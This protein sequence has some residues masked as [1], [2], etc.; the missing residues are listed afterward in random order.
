MCRRLPGITER[1][2][3]RKIT[4]REKITARKITEEIENQGDITEVGPKR[5]TLSTHGGCEKVWKKKNSHGK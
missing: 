4:V 2:R 3:E 5:A 1:E